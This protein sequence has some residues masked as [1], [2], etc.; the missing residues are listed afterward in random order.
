MVR[1]RL[2]ARWQPRAQ[3]QILRENAERLAN[4]SIEDEIA[5]QTEV[6]YAEY[7]GQIPAKRMKLDTD[8][9]GMYQFVNQTISDEAERKKHQKRERLPAEV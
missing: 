1:R 9:S 2:D 5:H 4:M 3:S 7:T 6:S 8:K